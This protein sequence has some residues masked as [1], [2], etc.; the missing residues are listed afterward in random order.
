MLSLPLTARWCPCCLASLLAWAGLPKV[1]LPL[2][3][4]PMLEYTLELL[5]SNSVQEVR[6]A[7]VRRGVWRV[8]CGVWAHP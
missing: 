8:A 4:V 3:N 7:C 5:A 1:L 2:V 6:G